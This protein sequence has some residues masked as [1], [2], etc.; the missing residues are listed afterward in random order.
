MIASAADMGLEHA[1]DGGEI[2]KFS[3]TSRRLYEKLPC[4]R[5]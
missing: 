3:D 4:Q 1:P 5:R 2:E